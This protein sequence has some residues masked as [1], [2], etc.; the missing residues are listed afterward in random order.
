MKPLREQPPTANGS[1]NLI[2][3]IVLSL[4]GLVV[5]ANLIFDLPTAAPTT[6]ELIALVG[7]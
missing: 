4:I 2:L 7:P 5:A 3:V 6:D 1:S